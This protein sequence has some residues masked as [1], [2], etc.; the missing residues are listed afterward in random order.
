[1]GKYD[2]MKYNRCGDSGVLLPGISLGLWHN[3]G[4]DAVYSNC[5]EM[6]LKSFDLGIIH[7]D[8]ANNYG[9]LPGS[10][11]ETF[12]RIF[13]NE[14]TAH[15]DEL[16]IASKAGFNMSEGPFGEWGS[17]KHLLNSLDK[18]LK[19]TGLEYFDIFYHHRPDPNTHLDETID[20]LEYAL[21]SGKALYVGV[22]N[23]SPEQ[24]K[25]VIEACKKRNIRL[26]IHQMNYNMFDRSSEDIVDVL[27]SY[28]IGSIAYCP[29][30]QGMLTNRYLGGIPD[31][32][33]AATEGTFLK[34]DNVTEDKLAKVR[35]LSEL[36]GKR[37]QTLA[38]M[39]LAWVL[40]RATSAIIGASKFLQIEENVRA[41]DNT[42]FSKDELAAIEKILI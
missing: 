26:L 20:A 3:F 30:A 2:N 29:L 19:R 39:A 41:L 14:L 15:R 7:F 34:R 23:Y 22:S 21:R 13:K 37:G 25:E 31:G 10:A 24:T 38:Q 42:H 36:A 28:S 32:S 9:P 1:M 40:Q 33:R 6:I 17:K 11:E 12:G 27:D 16:L 8:I 35:A 4:T 5:R 18:S